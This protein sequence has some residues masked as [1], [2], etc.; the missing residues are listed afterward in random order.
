MPYNLDAKLFTFLL[1]INWGS[2]QNTVEFWHKIPPIPAFKHREPTIVK[3]LYL[4]LRGLIL[5]FYHEILSSLVKPLLIIYKALLRN[6][7]DTFELHLV[8]YLNNFFNHSYIHENFDDLLG[9]LQSIRLLLRHNFLI[10][11]SVN[12]LMVNTL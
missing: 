7:L 9:D 12:K 11:K 6:K 10:L 5:K 4:L 8:L 1:I 2:T 3:C